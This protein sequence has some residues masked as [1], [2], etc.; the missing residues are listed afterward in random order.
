MECKRSEIVSATIQTCSRAEHGHVT[1]RCVAIR[2]D[3]TRRSVSESR[4]TRGL[5]DPFRS[6]IAI[7]VV[8]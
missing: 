5:N 6:R 7:H 2:Y 1:K 4:V 3:E 8:S